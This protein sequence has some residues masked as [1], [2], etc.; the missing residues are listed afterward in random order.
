VIA[1]GANGPAPPGQMKIYRVQD[2]AATS[3]DY[4]FAPQHTRFF[5]NS[6]SLFVSACKT[7]SSS[8]HIGNKR[9]PSFSVGGVW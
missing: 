5:R 7:E 6:S 8:Y 4:P 9:S 3:S 1:F 2:P